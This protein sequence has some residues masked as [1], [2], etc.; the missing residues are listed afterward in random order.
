MN[1]DT[2]THP[3]TNR[4]RCKS[5]SLIEANALSLRHTVPQRRLPPLVGGSIANP[6]Y[7]PFPSPLFILSVFLPFY[8][9]SLSLPPSRPAVPSPF[10]AHRCLGSN[11]L[12]EPGR[13]FC[14]IS[15]NTATKWPQNAKKCPTF[16]SLRRLPSWISSEMNWNHCAANTTYSALTYQIS[17]KSGDVRLSY[18]W[19][20]K[21]P[22]SFS[23]KGRYFVASTFEH[24]V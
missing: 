22:A 15:W 9:S 16:Q 7:F 23:G 14:A 17:I 21:F 8:F 3:S 2:V 20:N 1:P 13:Q 5:T 24:W 10:A 19:L 11:K 4:A 18:W 12:T 6:L